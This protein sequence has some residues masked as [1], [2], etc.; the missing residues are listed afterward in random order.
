MNHL[1]SNVETSDIFQANFWHILEKPVRCVSYEQNT[2]YTC[3]T[4]AQACWISTY[5]F[6][7]V[8]RKKMFSSI[9]ASSQW[10]LSSQKLIFRGLTSK[11]IHLLIA[12]KG[13]FLFLS[14]SKKPIS[15]IV[16]WCV[17]RFVITKKSVFIFITILN[18]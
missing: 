2:E 9:H 6:E 15:Q 10:L 5:R 4:L 1:T 7:L 13:H 17:C 8:G 18:L 3:G 14:K 11:V 12:S 16:F